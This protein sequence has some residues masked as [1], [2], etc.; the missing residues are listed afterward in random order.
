MPPGVLFYNSNG[1]RKLA[2][3]PALRTAAVSAGL[4]FTLTGC[5]VGPNFVHAAGPDVSGYT[6]S[7]LSSTT[8]ADVSGGGSQRFMTGANVSGL[9]WRALH[10]KQIDALVKEAIDNH[11]D[12]AAAQSAL[13][14][15]RE[16]AAADTSSLFPSITTDQSVTRNR[17]SAAQ[18]GQPG[19]A[20]LYT[21]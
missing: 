20:S 13:R 1:I 18:T 17:T 5:A 16:V 7:Q 14:Q 21:L 2:I 9:W 4:G 8:S 6:V 12:L 3:A 19:S 10:S 11:P 15:A